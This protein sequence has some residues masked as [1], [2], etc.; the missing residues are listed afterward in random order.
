M[1]VRKEKL[2]IF[3]RRS[4]ETEAHEL[5]L[6]D[7]KSQIQF[8]NNKKHIEMCWTGWIY[9]LY[10]KG[11]KHRGIVYPVHRGQPIGILRY[12]IDD[13]VWIDDLYFDD[14]YPEQKAVESNMFKLFQNRLAAENNSIIHTFSKRAIDYLDKNYNE[15]YFVGKKRIWNV[16]NGIQAYIIS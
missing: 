11:T 12:S 10:E 6:K 4:L 1:L 5:R 2:S 8:Y 16:I 15:I 3:R 9:T 13:V 14:R 7:I